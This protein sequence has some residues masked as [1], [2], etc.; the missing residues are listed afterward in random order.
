MSS[1]GAS[2]RPTAAGPGASRAEQPGRREQNRARQRDRIQEAAF[3]LFAER[4]FDDVTV[5]DVAREAGVA[6]ATVFNHFSSKQGLVEAI[7]VQVLLAYTAMLDAALADARAPVPRL[8][9]ALFDGMGAGIENARRF[10]RG[11]FREIARLQLG[12]DE[13]GPADR[14]NAA[15]HERLVS[16]FARGQERGEIRRDHGPETLAAAF[17]NLAN[18]TITRWLFEETAGSLRQRMHGAIEV[19]LSP[20]AATGA[21]DAAPLPDLLPPSFV[22]PPP[23]ARAARRR[24]A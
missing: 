10:Q 23:K 15:N 17:S 22:P 9:R 1:R 24:G 18:G 4:G 8:L 13:G 6:R 5:E 16:L 3:A 7:T 2:R 19:L 11:V 12:F 14:V 21:R 20:V